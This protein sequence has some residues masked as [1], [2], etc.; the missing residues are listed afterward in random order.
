MRPQMLNAESDAALAARPYSRTALSVDSLTPS[1][2]FLIGVRDCLAY[3]FLY[4][5]FESFEEWVVQV[6]RFR[7]SGI[8]NDDS[9]PRGT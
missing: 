3:L 4:F 9:R 2:I 8:V 5:S 1:A 6:V 7:R